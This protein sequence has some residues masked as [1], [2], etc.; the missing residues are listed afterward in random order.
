[1]TQIK[2]K[3]L[4][5]LP[6]AGVLQVLESF[7]ALNVPNWRGFNRLVTKGTTCN[8]I[9][10]ACDKSAIDEKRVRAFKLMIQVKLHDS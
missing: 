6:I 2:P 1:M 4:Y 5:I 9:A 3:G 8:E 7:V 10:C